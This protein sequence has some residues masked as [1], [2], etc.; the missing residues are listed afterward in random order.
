MTKNQEFDA[1]IV[2]AGFS[3]MYMLHLL[4]EEGLSV[5][6]YEAG[7]NVGGTW[8]W[9]RYPGA[10]CDIP[11]EF[12][13]YTFSEEIHREWT[14]S[15]VYPEQS[16]ILDYCNFVAN[17][18]DLRRDIE[19]NTRLTSAEYDEGNKRWK[20]ST[21]DG[22]V[23]QAKYFIPALGN[24]SVPHAPKIKGLEHFQGE[25]YHTSRWPHEE[26][27]FKGKRVAVIGTG[28]SG[29][30]AITSISKEAEHLTVFQR[31]AQFVTPVKNPLLSPDQVKEMKNNFPE[32]RRQIREHFIG[33]PAFDLRRPYSALEDS[34]EERQKLYEE[35]WQEQNG[36]QLLFSYLDITLDD[37]ANATL[38]EFVRT[39]IKEIVKDPEKAENLLPTYLIGGKRPVVATNYYETYNQKNVSLINL[40]KTPIVECTSKGLRTTEGEYELDVIVFAS[41]FDAM[42]GPLMKANIRGK[43][44]IL[45]KDKWEDGKNLKTFLGVCNVGFPNMFTITGPHFPLTTNA[46]TVNELIVEWIFDCI[47]HVEQHGIEEVEATA[48]AEVTWTNHV[49]EVGSQSIY[50]K[51][52]SWYTGANIEGKP[53]AFL[54][55]TGDYL[56]FQE[57]FNNARDYKGFTLTPKQNTTVEN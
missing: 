6:L 50:A 1:I 52:D 25:T 43:N 3:G 14:W 16:E 9:N 45:L 53:R 18:L 48:E 36:F 21:G 32:L 10:R 12:Y 40:K 24:V 13:C 34:P 54:G 44:G 49:N 22:D 29:V 19:F 55:Y 56:M 23:V 11:T 5:R 57:Q 17:K 51:V 41:G 26:V 42:T 2:G 8:Y 37:D 35:L 38:A 39:K 30:Q 20:V 28:S 33:A 27:D 47:K 7:E 31:T 4:R 46:I 15:S